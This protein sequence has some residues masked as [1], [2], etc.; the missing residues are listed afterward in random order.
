ME[1]LPDT[2]GQSQSILS[3]QP[4][5]ISSRITTHPHDFFTPQPVLSASVYLLRM[6][7]HDWPTPASVDI[8]RNLLPALKTHPETSRIVIMDTVLPVPGS[9][10]V[11]EEALLRVRDLTMMQAF[12]NR[13]RELGEFEDVFAQV[14]DDEGGL[15]LK[16]VKKMPGSVMSVMEVAYEKGSPVAIASTAS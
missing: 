14:R 10:G 7:L 9:V 2:V 16:N 6:I 5:P 11:V 15:V 12:N 3:G 13:E 8:L 4:E 1:D